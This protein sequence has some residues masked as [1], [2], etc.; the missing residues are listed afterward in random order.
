MQFYSIA[1]TIINTEIKNS[2]IFY[3]FTNKLL[4]IFL[5]IRIF[6]VINYCYLP[7]SKK[8]LLCVLGD[9]IVIKDKSNETKNKMKK[10]ETLR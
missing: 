9:T 4:S 5:K 2:S 6:V 1:N 3:I 8:A 10:F 7:S